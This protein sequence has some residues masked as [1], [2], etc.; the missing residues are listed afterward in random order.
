MD[1]GIPISMREFPQRYKQYSLK[2]I[3]MK[4]RKT[5]DYHEDDGCCMFFSFSYDK[6]GNVLGEPPEVEFSSGYLQDDFDE[7]K[8]THFVKGDEFNTI[9]EQADPEAFPVFKRPI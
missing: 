2:G 3:S 1:I 8:W 9:F 6:N 4:L 5:E 7:T